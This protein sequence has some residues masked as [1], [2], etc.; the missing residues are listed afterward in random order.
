MMHRLRQPLS[1]P[2]SSSLSSLSR[3]ALRTH[4]QLTTPSVTVPSASYCR[5][6]YYWSSAPKDANT[7]KAGDNEHY[8]GP[9]WW[10][11]WDSEWHSRWGYARNDAKVG[12]NTHPGPYWWRRDA[13]GG[14]KEYFAS[15]G[16]SFGKKPSQ[17]GQTSFTQ[18]TEQTHNVEVLRPK[19]EVKRSE[20]A[21]IIFV[22]MPGLSKGDVKIK[23]TNNELLV[24][25]EKKVEKKDDSTA[26]AVER[27]YSRAFTIDENVQAS[28]LT[29]KME[30]G[31]LQITIPRPKEQPGESDIQ[32][33]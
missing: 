14:E 12:E 31:I 23:I 3:N 4:F 27:A 32:I 18:A 24:S 16:F 19:A 30:N 20:E 7:A 25:G 2:I 33:A 21:T 17:Q 29:A 15:F 10:K 22:E 11:K 26:N 5:R 13:K 9:S 1:A 8:W 6:A 28:T